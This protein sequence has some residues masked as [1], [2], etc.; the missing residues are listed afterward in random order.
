M[1]SPSGKNWQSLVAAQDFPRL[2]SFLSASLPD[3]SRAR[4][5]KLIESGDVLVD[6]KAAKPSQKIRAGSEVRYALPTAAAPTALTPEAIPLNVIFEN[7][8]MLVVDKPA[9]LVVHPAH[10]NWSG[11]LVNALL[12]HVGDK[13]GKGGFSIGGELRPGIVHRIDKNTSGILVVA[14]TDAA[15]ALLARQ[16]KE[17]TIRRMYRGIC[18][19]E[20]PLKGEFAGAIGRDPRERK[21]MT[22]VETGG[23]RALTKYRVLE[24]LPG[25]AYFEAELHTGRTHQIRAHFA[26]GGFPLVGDSLYASATRSARK[27][28][29]R[30]MNLLRQADPALPDQL[31]ELTREGKRQ[32]LHA[33]YLALDGGG[34]VGELEFTSEPPADFRKLL[35][36]LRK[37]R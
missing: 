6:G 17:H 23:K 25:C 18:W 5:Q 36:L 15:F 24:R 32:M 30:G 20:P 13:L 22:V 37:S 9:G 34:G 21:R 16:F 35:A 8:A 3:L 27:A 31:L 28:Q 11:T 12:A 4:A 14:K 1:T 7:D 33:G 26:A 10:G 29:V 2:D 19:G